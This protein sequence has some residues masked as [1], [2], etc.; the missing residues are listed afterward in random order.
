MKAASPEHE[1]NTNL[2]ND[3]DSLLTVAPAQAGV[4]GKR[5]LPATPGS[6]QSLPLARTG[7]QALGSRFR[8]NDE[9]VS[10]WLLNVRTDPLEPAGGRYSARASEGER[11]YP[12][13]PPAVGPAAI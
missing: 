6:S 5:S 4:Q 3:S 12:L 11:P 10:G 9:A 13:T 1:S 7:G 8:G 2:T